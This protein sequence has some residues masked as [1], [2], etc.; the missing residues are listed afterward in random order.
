MDSLNI[1]SISKN[2][3][4]YL[5]ETEIVSIKDLEKSINSK[6]ALRHFFSSKLNLYFPNLSGFTTSFAVMVMMKSKKCLSVNQTYCSEIPYLK[7]FKELEKSNLLSYIKNNSALK[8]YIPD[9]IKED[10]IS[11]DFM[12]L[13]IFHIDRSY[14]N[15]LFL[16]Y[17]KIKESS[18]MFF[19]NRASIKVD[20]EF[21]NQLKTY[22]GI[23]DGKKNKQFFAV[24]SRAVA[25]FLNFIP[26]I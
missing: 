7:G 13:L 21:L 19:K 9:E 23:E 10:R 5:M 2:I 12:I 24:T 14:Y 17:K 4:F 26:K 20:Q 6:R 3:S 22:N 8:M 15:W 25:N 1:Q 11:R 16:L 18:N